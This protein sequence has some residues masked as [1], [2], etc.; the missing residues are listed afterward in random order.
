MTREIVAAGY[1][2]SVTPEVVYRERDRE[3]VQAVPVESLLVESDGPWRYRGE[4]EGLPSGPWF[5]SRVAE[6]IAK[7]KQMPV[8]DVMHQLS[9]NACRLFDLVWV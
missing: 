6:E 3:L 9:T 5:A 4:F 1:L 7:L 8:E 2:V